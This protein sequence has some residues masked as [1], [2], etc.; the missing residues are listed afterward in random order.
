MSMQ[1]PDRLPSLHQLANPP[2]HQYGK[3]AQSN[4]RLT[5]LRIAERWIILKRTIFV[6]YQDFLVL[7][8]DI[9]VSCY[10]NKISSWLSLYCINIFSWLSWNLSRYLGILVLHS[11][12]HIFVL[13]VMC[14]SWYCIEICIPSIEN[15]MLSIVQGAG[16]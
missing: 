5:F 14:I 10:Y 3:A 16:A 8:P 11:E 7:Y 2:N 9:L 1:D 6:L 13:Y 15:H 12:M 4:D